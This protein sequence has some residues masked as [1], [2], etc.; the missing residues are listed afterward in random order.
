MDDDNNKKTPYNY[1]ILAAVDQ[2][3]A[4]SRDFVVGRGWSPLVNV[5][6]TSETREIDLSSNEYC[7]SYV[8]Y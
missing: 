2:S 3:I 1:R 8:A 4:A 6:M 5:G 7:C